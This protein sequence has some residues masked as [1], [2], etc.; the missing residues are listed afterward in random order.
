M[1]KALRYN[2]GKNMLDLIPP[3]LIEEIGKILTFGAK[4][5]D[6]YN[7]R[8]GMEWSKCV[9]SLKRHLLSF[10]NGIDYDSESGQLHISHV[11]VNAMFLL[12]YYK[13]YPQGDDRQHTYLKK[14]RIALD[15]DEVLA[16]FCGALME[17]FDD[18]KERPVYWN[19]VFIYKHWKEIENDDEFW[20]NIKPKINPKELPFEPIAYVTSR[21]VP[22]IITESWLKNCGFPVAEVVTIGLNESKVEVLK[23]RNI[24][25]FVDDKFDNFVDINNAGI[26]CYLMD[27][28]HNR[29]YEVGYK[30]IF[31]LKELI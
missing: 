26:C 17:R 9:A 14:R 19:D 18:I 16:D 11:I 7:Y 25:I 22:Q 3:V 24:D 30:R 31:D 27:A 1:D 15:I 10:E 2:E 23:Q 8:K 13:I 6:K 12:E 5:Y 29:R 21:N 4:K 20:L 28:P